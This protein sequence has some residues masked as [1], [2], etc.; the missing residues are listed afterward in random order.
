M[1]PAKKATPAKKS[2]P[3]KSSRTRVAEQ[4][5][6]NDA[7]KDSTLVEKSTGHIKHREHGSVD[8]RSAHRKGHGLDQQVKSLAHIYT[9][10]ANVRANG[11]GIVA[12]AAWSKRLA[13][14]GKTATKGAAKKAGEFTRGLTHR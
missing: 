6:V 13:D 5:G 9:P 7:T 4:M 2:T 14:E 1:T 11:S 3:A 10:W 12:I 8:A